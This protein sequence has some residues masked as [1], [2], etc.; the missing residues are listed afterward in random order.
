MPIDIFGDAIS[1]LNE[2]QSTI[3]D[4]MIKRIFI[5]ILSL[6]INFTRMYASLC[7]RRLVRITDG[8]GNQDVINKEQLEVVRIV[9]KNEFCDFKGKRLA[10]ITEA[11]GPKDAVTL[12]QINEMFKKLKEI[13]DQQMSHFNQKII[14]L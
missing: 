3:T 2:Q 5:E 11:I 13:K 14:L 1:K 10:H 9:G 6:Y 4:N 8:I 7:N 12:G